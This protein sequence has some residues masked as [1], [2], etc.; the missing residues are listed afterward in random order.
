MTFIPCSSLLCIILI[1]LE[2]AF[3]KNIF[4]GIKRADAS[5]SFKGNSTCMLYISTLDKLENLLLQKY[6]KR[7]I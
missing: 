4:Y 5:E 2:N 1:Y 7:E 6:R 3:I